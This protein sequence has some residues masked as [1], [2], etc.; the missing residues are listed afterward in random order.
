MLKISFSDQLQQQ[1]DQFIEKVA[2]SV[3]AAA[4]GR[5]LA[6]EERHLPVTGQGFHQHLRIPGE[7]LGH[8]A[9]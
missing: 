4:P 9:G 2:A 3:N 1:L 7:G 6:G 8:S 5:F